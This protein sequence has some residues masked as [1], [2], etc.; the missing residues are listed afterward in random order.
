MIFWVIFIFKILNNFLYKSII[1]GLHSRSITKKVCFQINFTLAEVGRTW[2][3]CPGTN[4][5]LGRSESGQTVRLAEVSVWPN[6]P[7][8][9]LSRDELSAWPKCPIG[10][11]VRGRTVQGRTVRLAELSRDE[12]SWAEVSH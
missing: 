2:P 8:A 7:V 12:L 1:L 4:C 9:E 10:R 3:I 11:S 5:P 6:C